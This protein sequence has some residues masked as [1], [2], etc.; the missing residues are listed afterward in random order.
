MP[1]E[2]KLSSDINRKLAGDAAGAPLELSTSDRGTR[3][4]KKASK[5][6]KKAAAVAAAAPVPPM[7]TPGLEPVAQ[8]PYQPPQQGFFSAA[9]RA[10]EAPAQVMPHAQVQPQMQPQGMY[11]PQ[12]QMQPQMPA[13]HMP[14]PQAPQQAPMHPQVQAAVQ[15][16]MPPMTAAAAQAE[17]PAE[18]APAPAP[19]QPIPTDFVTEREH[20]VLPIPFTVQLGDDRYEGAG[21]SLTHVYI[22]RTLET[23]LETGGASR[24]AQV[25]FTFDGFQIDLTPEVRVVSG[26]ESSELG[27]EFAD[28]TGTHLPQLRYIINSFIAGDFVTLGAFLSYTGPVKP[29]GVKDADVKI[30]RNYVK[31]AIVGAA[32]VA[33]IGL[34]ASLLMNRYVF[35]Y[36][37]R[38]IFVAQ[39]GQDMRSTSA[40]QITYLNPSAVQ[41]DVIFSISANS[42]D[43]LNFQ[44]PCDCEV[45]LADGIYE[46]ATVLP[47]DPIL[48]FHRKGETAVTVEAMMS[49]DGLSRAV[50]GDSVSIV[51]SDGRKIPVKVIQSS[52]TNAAAQQGDLYLPVTLEPTSGSLDAGD[53]GKP[54]RVRLMKSIF[55]LPNILGYFRS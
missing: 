12:P 40:G 34:A 2:L 55:R 47:S 17:A 49:V 8:A 9:L 18:P 3:S 30:G 37:A 25:K 32:C 19:A 28:P 52:A 11:A 14:Q 16:A 48:T 33:V 27:L 1:G 10:P 46:G 39:A 6:S 29:K 38:P 41:G 36:E 42:G 45:R 15:E 22:K 23:E 35:S 31:S 26:R 53:I 7:P 50:N 54:G 44:L 13:E 21:L 5:R 20:P 4:K 51:M 43:I 24:L